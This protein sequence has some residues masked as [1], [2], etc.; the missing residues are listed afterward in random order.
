MRKIVDLNKSQR[1]ETL[2]AKC[3]NINRLSGYGFNVPISYAIPEAF[4]TDHLTPL[5]NE[6]ASA[7]KYLHPKKAADEVETMFLDVGIAENL[8][9]QLEQLLA[10]LPSN[11]YF[12]IRSSGSCTVKGKQ[13][14][15]DSGGSALAGLFDSFLMVQRHNMS[16]AILRCWSSIYNERNIRLFSDSK[17]TN[18]SGTMS[19]L[20]QE[21]VEA[22]SSAVMM[23]R[24]PIDSRNV[25]GI[26]STNGPCEALV[27]GKVTGDFCLIDRD[28]GIII[29]HQTGSKAHLVAYSEFFAIGNNCYLVENKRND[30][31]AIDEEMLKA[32]AD[33]GMEI[34][35]SFGTPMDIEA[36]LKD[37]IWVIV[38]ARPITTINQ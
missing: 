17:V 31:P 4:F 11:I 3:D 18:Y 10:D 12:A 33:I 36:I 16:D 2:G 24:D 15:E 1:L 14:K 29:E 13:I 7:I 34:E 8:Q 22:D 30:L 20:I 26:E 27:S 19:V 35:D 9:Y 5:A 28:S 25:L 38:Q 37:K 21:M 32:L 6:V 23:T